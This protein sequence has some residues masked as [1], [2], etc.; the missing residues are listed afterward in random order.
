MGFVLTVQNY[1]FASHYNVKWLA[2]FTRNASLPQTVSIHLTLIPP[3][4]AFSLIP[5]SLPILRN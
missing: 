1:S 2:L 4:H 3:P 5:Q